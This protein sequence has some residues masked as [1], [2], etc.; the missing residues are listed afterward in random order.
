MPNYT[1]EPATLDQLPEITEL[2]YELFSEETDFVADREKQMRGVRLILEHPNRGRIFVLQKDGHIFGM[3]NLLI[4]IS[5]AE[6]GFVIILEDLV[7]HKQHRGMGYGSALLNYA[8]EFA[9]KKKFLRITL[10]AENARHPSVEFFKHHGFY[11]SAMTPMRLQLE[12]VG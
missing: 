3:I 8:I 5:T 6:G 4:T 1:I 9:K 12:P 11:Q 10:L 7:V 2:L